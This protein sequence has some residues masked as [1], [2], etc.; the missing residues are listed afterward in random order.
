MG[1]SCRE[2]LGNQGIGSR[3]D[4]L[5]FRSSDFTKEVQNKC[6]EKPLTL[7]DSGCVA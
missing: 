1:K 7:V 5:S 2:G 3:N 6:T 4:L